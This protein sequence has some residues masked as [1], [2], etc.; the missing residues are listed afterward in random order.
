MD[1]SVFATLRP[2]VGGRSV[3]VPLPEGATVQ[4]LVDQL[5]AQWPE[6]G[7]HLFEEDRSLSRRVNIFLDG[8]NIRWLD[9][10]LTPVGSHQKV[11]IFPPVAGG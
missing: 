6:L 7:E 8:R 4:D 9:G 5:A 10:L 11:D 3:E 2:I 1:V